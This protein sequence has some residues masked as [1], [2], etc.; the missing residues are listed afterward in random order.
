M[1]GM[2]SNLRF[3]VPDLARVLPYTQ[4]QSYRRRRLP[5]YDTCS[6]YTQALMSF[7]SIQSLSLSCEKCQLALNIV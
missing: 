2:W 4:L 7:E 1:D 3:G 5:Q 6:Q